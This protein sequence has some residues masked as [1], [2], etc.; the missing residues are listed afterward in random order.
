MTNISLTYDLKEKLLKGMEKISIPVI[1]TLGPSGRNVMIKND[2]GTIRVTKDGVTV[3]RAFKK[4]EDPIEDFAVQLLKQVS[5]NSAKKAG[6]G[7]TTSTLLAYYLTLEALSEIRNDTNVIDLKRGMEYAIN[8]TIEYIKSISKDIND[9]DTLFNVAKISA[10]ND[11]YIGK[12]VSSAI[13]EVGRDGLVTLEES[14]TGETRI[15]VVEGVMIDRGMKS[16][17]FVTD[18]NNM[19]CVLENCYI[20][21]TSDRFS[22]AKQVVNLFQCIERL[23]VDNKN[24]LLIIA[25]DFDEEALATLIVNK[26]RGSIR[27]CAIK[28]PGYAENRIHLLEDIAAIT[29]AQVISNTKG[30]SLNKLNPSDYEKL[31]GK[32]RLVN[33]SKDDTTIIDGKGDK[34]KITDRLKEIENQLINSKSDFES[35]KLQERIGRMTGGVAII[36]VGGFSDA[37]IKEKK[38]RVED[39]LFATK[40]ALDKGIVPGGSIALI[41]AYKKLFP[42]LTSYNHDYYVG[43]QVALRSILKPYH[44]ML[45]NSGIMGEALES[46][47]YN[48]LEEGEGWDFKTFEKVNMIEKGII[49]PTKVL[50]TALEN[51]LS[52]A[53]VILSCDAAVYEENDEENKL[54]QPQFGF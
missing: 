38:D 54:N 32:S 3:A 47:D 9:K 31:L 12:I 1:S 52:I 15:D 10:N 34:E 2:D 46:Y 42:I 27:V 5:I 17:Y 6:D 25:E 22:T 21:L 13:D 23:D 30:L 37:E 53:G 48:L 7:T 24:S 33:V 49:D 41:Q 51:A 8:Q 35:E 26:A 45:K 39:S 50:I 29:G 28:A 44:Q 36:S 11:E 43:I 20:C 4:L 16:P 40:A 19:T 14:R 18:N